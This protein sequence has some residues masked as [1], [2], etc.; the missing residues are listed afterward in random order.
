VAAMGMGT[1]KINSQLLT[2]CLLL[3][4]FA[5]CT[6]RKPIEDTEQVV[7]ADSWLSAFAILIGYV[8]ALCAVAT[9][10]E[11]Y[12]QHKKRA[13]VC[14]CIAFVVFF[15]AALS[16]TRDFMA[17]RITISHDGVVSTYFL[18]QFEFKW[19]DVEY[20]EV[21]ESSR[22][23]RYTVSGV[24]H[25]KNDADVVFGW[26]NVR[27]QA[28]FPDI[29]SGLMKNGITIRDKNNFLERRKQNNGGQ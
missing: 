5:G 9:A 11:F 2:V 19:A 24:F 3:T 7:I 14:C 26:D 25:L 16:A 10:I 29:Y 15:L 13:S 4:M 6:Q 27:F 17:G 1:M 23:R 28:A 12:K 20:F 21:V 18:D 8:F 22:S